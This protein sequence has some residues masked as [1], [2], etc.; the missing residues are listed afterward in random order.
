MGE[1]IGRAEVG[2][3]AKVSGA[4][5][6]RRVRGAEA[7]ATRWL[8]IAS[9][10]SNRGGKLDGSW[11]EAGRWLCRGALNSPNLMEPNEGGVCS[12]NESFD[13][14]LRREIGWGL[15]CSRKFTALDRWGQCAMDN[16]DPNDSRA[17]G[18]FGGRAG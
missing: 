9:L 14:S 11:T 12:S 17:S 8:E 1:R 13:I 5:G 3:E 15:A 6:E 16:C 4:K 7:A 2:E 18:L 10:L